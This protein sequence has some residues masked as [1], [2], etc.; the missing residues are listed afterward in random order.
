MS[1]NQPPPSPWK[2]PKVVSLG[3]RTKSLKRK[4]EIFNTLNSENN[5]SLDDSSLPSRDAKIGKTIFNRFSI[6]RDSANFSFKS[7]EKN[8]PAVILKLS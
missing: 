4:S 2:K 3:N 5:P 8:L 6:N 7:S 1:S